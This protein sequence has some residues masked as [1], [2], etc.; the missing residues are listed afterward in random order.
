M[1]VFDKQVSYLETASFNV[2]GVFSSSDALVTKELLYALVNVFSPPFICLG[3]SVFGVFVEGELMLAYMVFFVFFYVFCLFELGFHVVGK[4]FACYVERGFFGVFV[5]QVFAGATGRGQVSRVAYAQYRWLVVGV[6][7][8]VF[9][10]RD[11][12]RG[13]Y[14]YISLAR[15]VCLPCT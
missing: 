15:Q 8:M 6:M 12:R 4:F 7:A 14:T 5:L 13:G 3:L 10:G 1:E 2:A 11:W 9:G